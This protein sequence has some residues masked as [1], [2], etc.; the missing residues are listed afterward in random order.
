[1]RIDIDDPDVDMDDAQRL[2]YRGTAFTGEAAEYHGGKLIS[3]DSYTEGI[4]DGPACEW[5]PNGA[6]RSEGMSRMGFPVGEQKEWHPNGVLASRRLFSDDG[7][8]LL[9]E[10]KW[11]EGGE[12][13]RSW[14]K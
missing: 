5:Y 9:E 2:L 8:R 12:M 7:K 4:Q 10:D 14:R 3:L 13:V 1:M 6:R 11:D